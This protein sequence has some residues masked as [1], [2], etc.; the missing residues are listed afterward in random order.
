MSSGLSGVGGSGGSGCAGLLGRR[1]GL[2]WT[3]GW[4]SGLGLVW[5]WFVAVGLMGVEGTSGKGR[6]PEGRMWVR[7]RIR[8]L[9]MI[10]G[11]GR[12]RRDRENWNLQR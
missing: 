6:R 8:E 7:R 2:G 12:S 3:G 4:V 11:R 5:V 9:E 10:G 1:G